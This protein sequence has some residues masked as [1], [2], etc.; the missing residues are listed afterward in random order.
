MKKTLFILLGLMTLKAEA[1]LL[2]VPFEGVRPTGMGNA[3]LSLADDQNMLW[4]NPAA[5]AK[6]KKWRFNLFD[7]TMGFDS[8][9]TLE[10]MRALIFDG[11]SD[12]LVSD[13]ITYLRMAL[14]PA[15]FG[16]NFGV[17]LYTNSQGFFEIRNLDLPEV[18]VYA[19]SDIAA[20]AGVG[21][22]IGPN[23]SVGVSARAIYRTSVDATITTVDLLSELGGITEE[24]FMN[25]VYARLESLSGMGYGF[26]LNLGA[27]LEVPTGKG[28]PRVAAA[29]TIEDFGDTSFTAMGSENAPTA[30]P[31]SVNFGSSVSYKSSKNNEVN[32][33]IDF[34]H[35]FEGYSLGQM[36]HVGLEWKHKAFSFRAG[37]YQLYPTFGFSFEVLPHTKIHMSSYAVEIGDES[38]PYSHRWWLVQAIIGFNPF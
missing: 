28:G 35:L 31:Q 3:F 27:H 4:Y 22:P 30:I 38:S 34:R 24:D 21:I 26:G 32:F 1:R 33:A 9:T 14:K 8:L 25:A 16:P 29:F 5:L 17:A 18:D 10:Q 19:F 37:L 13:D 6:N 11:N 2:R 7:F 23:F 20:I 15:L 36:S 12:D